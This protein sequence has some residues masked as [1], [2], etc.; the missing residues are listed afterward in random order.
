MSNWV[1]IEMGACQLHDARHAKRLAQLLGRLSEKPVHSIPSAC[2]GWAETV[3]AYRFLDNPAIGE[4]EILSGHIQAT[5][6]RI[7]TQDVVLL[8][9]DTTFLDYGTT[10]PKKGLGTVK[11]KVRAEHLLHPT[12][13]FTPAR[14][15]LGVLGLKMWQRPEQPV[16]QERHRQP[17]AE[18]ESS[19]WL[20][21]YQLAC[22]VQQSCPDTLVVN[23]ADR[24]GD[25]H[26]WFLDA[27]QRLPGERAEFIIR[28]KCHRRIAKGQA[29]RYLWEELQKARAAG[30]MTVELTRQPDRPPRQVTL[31]VAVK[32]VPCNGAR[33]PGGRLPP[34]EVVAVYAKECRP[35]RGEE[36]IA[37]LLLTSW[38][39]ADFPSA[40]TVV[41]WYRC[42]WEIELLFRVL[43]QGC[44]I[45][46]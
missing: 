29:P 4:Q 44:Q 14:L 37:G 5:L 18:Q 41:Q 8:G 42:R 20:E 34:V 3:A 1:G 15:N 23:V 43:K 46:P 11:V 2:H 32:R 27:L 21:G 28:A 38:P 36:P 30:R 40:C 12:V 24:E 6:E 9:Q 19:R 31:R 35:P 45:E 22:E 39:V 7:R 17:L 13:A 16:A 26:E 25:I 10:R 33:R